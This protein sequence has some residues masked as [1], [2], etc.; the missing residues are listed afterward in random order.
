[1]IDFQNAS[2]V[3]YSHNSEFL[4]DGVFR[5]KI[6]KQLSVDGYIL[7]L[8]N[9]DGVSGIW[10][11]MSGFI[12]GATDYDAILLNGVNFGS[13]KINT[14]NF[15]Q[16]V[17]V[18]VKNYTANV[19]IWDSGNL[20]NLDQTGTGS[21]YSGINVNSYQYIDSLS[22]TFDFSLSENNTSSYNHNVSIRVRS[23]EIA[24]PILAAKIIAQNLFSGTNLQ[25]FLGQQ[26]TGFNTRKNYRESYNLITSECSFEER[27]EFG[28]FSGNYSL[29]YTNSFDVAENG[30]INVRENG[31]I[32]GLVEPR[33]GAAE[34]GWNTERN[35]VFGRCSGIFDIYA[36][37]GAYVLNTYPIQKGLEI[38][39][40]DGVITY[41]MGYTNDPRINDLYSWE[42]TNRLNRADNG[43]YT[44]SE[45]G[46]IAG[47]GRRLVEKFP[48]ALSGWVVISGGIESRINNFYTGN[49]PTPLLP[50][51]LVNETNG[52][53]E[54][55]G[56]VVYA[57]TYTDDLTL[58]TGVP[59]KKLEYSI[60][61]QEV[62]HLTNKYNIMNVKEVIQPAGIGTL[63]Q[64]AL[65]I[66]MNGSRTAVLA[67]YISGAKSVAANHIPSGKGSDTYIAGVNY[68][69]NKNENSF[70]FKL[71]WNFHNY[72]SFTGISI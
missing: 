68:D 59:I 42:Y 19:T 7:D 36:P 17:D 61:D 13:G 45:N 53:S 31:T 11:G 51:K 26:Y 5:Y 27:V 34:S 70:S 22:E 46:N 10:S 72:H 30:V 20:F 25:G 65:S 40:F 28:A 14:I 9:Q 69:W 23:G 6:T 71:N 18:R 52:R 29:E 62:V 37:S 56:T 64:R 43:V 48:N 41:N 2:L 1:M 38:N 3:S 15:R 60:A 54:Y 21:Y 33:Y 47:F 16:G 49:V 35:N 55:E 39:T 67:D 4:G 58:Q 24:N 12:S 8:S 57:R 66:N 63:G 50:L 32:R 44:V